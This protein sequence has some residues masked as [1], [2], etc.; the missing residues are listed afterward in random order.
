MPVYALA[1]SDGRGQDCRGK[2]PGT[3][4][5]PRIAQIGQGT[6]RLLA[7]A[8]QSHAATLR[9]VSEMANPGLFIR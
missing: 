1:T 7:I 5:H 8:Q 6:L 3:G 9:G 2:A 4:W